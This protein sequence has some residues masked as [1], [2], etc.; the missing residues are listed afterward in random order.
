MPSEQQLIAL[1]L[2]ELAI[3][4]LAREAL[5]NEVLLYALAQRHPAINQVVINAGT[6]AVCKGVF[7][8]CW[9]E[10]VKFVTAQQVFSLQNSLK[11]SREIPIR[12]LLC[13][14]NCFNAEGHEY[15]GVVYTDRQSY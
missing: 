11:Q 5:N 14:H 7:V 3:R 9:L 8:H 6:C 1:P 4:V 12:T 10:C 2:Q 15:L 13:S